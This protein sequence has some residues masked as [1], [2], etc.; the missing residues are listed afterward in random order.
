MKYL[1]VL[2]FYVSSAH[3]QI[4]TPVNT[5]LI[6]AVAYIFKSEEKVKKT[7][8]PVG[9]S[10]QCTIQ[11][12]EISEDSGTYGVKSWENALA[13]FSCY[14]KHQL[15]EKQ[16]EIIKEASKHFGV[17]DIMMACLFLM[18]SR[19]DPKAQSPFASGIAQFT[20]QTLKTIKSWN[21]KP[22]DSSL[23]ACQK[24]LNKDEQ[25]YCDKIKQRMEFSTQFE[26]MNKILVDK[27]LIPSGVRFDLW[28]KY[29]SI[30]L[31]TMYMKKLI[32][33]VRL[34]TKPFSRDSDSFEN[35][36]KIVKMALAGYNMGEG[37]VNSKINKLKRNNAQVNLTMALKEVKK[38]SAES[39]GH[40][41]GIER[42]IRDKNFEGPTDKERYQQC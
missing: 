16:I 30:V 22:S 21:T 42:C 17:N 18:E 5:Y 37:N 36:M 32:D 26:K 35:E 12:N 6:K 31:S 19:F 8:T 23:R 38:V 34:K 11:T 20:P 3:C 7:L 41:D 28:D 39:A 29:S 4:I 10:N 15:D 14:S 25:I 33:N 40:M 13:Y 2:F 9:S 1:L 27:K 24:E